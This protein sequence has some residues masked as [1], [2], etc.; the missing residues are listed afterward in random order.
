[1]DTIASLILGISLSTA[2]G[3]RVFLPLLIASLA[4]IV[5]HLHLPSDLAWV[6]SNQAL[7]MFVAASVLEILGYSIPWIDH[8]LELVAIPL[9][10][11]AGTFVTA[12]TAPEMNPLV[13]WATAII[14][15]GGAAG[16]TKSLMS[17]LRIGST[18]TTGGLANPLLTVFEVVAAIAISVLALTLPVL[19]GV[20]GLVVVG[21]IGF[22]V[23]RIVKPQVQTELSA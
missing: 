5:G 4:A 11:L 1:M 22:R 15:G 3:F 18:A 20:V 13:H 17:L 21:L 6:G 9:A 2:C 8:A 10:I 19:A 12:S 16:M 7:V 23:W 14:A